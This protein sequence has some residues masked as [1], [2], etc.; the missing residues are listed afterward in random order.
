MPNRIS[1]STIFAPETAQV[2]RQVYENAIKS[3]ETTHPIIVSED[4]VRETLVLRIIET[5]KKGERD[6]ACLHEDA[7]AHLASMM[8]P[9]LSG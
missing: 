7:L 3:L 6:P 1:Q 8:P 9:P 4:W 5:A 2:M